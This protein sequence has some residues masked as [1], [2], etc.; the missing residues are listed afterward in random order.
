MIVRE[1]TRDSSFALNARACYTLLTQRP[2][3]NEVFTIFCDLIVTQ[4]RGGKQAKQHPEEI[5]EQNNEYCS[6]MDIGDR[7][8]FASALCSFLALALCLYQVA[9]PPLFV[10]LYLRSVTGLLFVSD[11]SQEMTLI[12]N[13]LITVLR[14]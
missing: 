9:C 13:R 11:V 12:A 10:A 3:L 14:T 7:L 5:L 1:T 8:W 2:L 6:L 4:T